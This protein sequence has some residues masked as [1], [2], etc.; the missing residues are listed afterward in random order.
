MSCGS[1][2]LRVRTFSEAF[3]PVAEGEHA[4][5]AVAALHARDERVERLRIDKKRPKI[6]SRDTL[7][8]SRASGGLAIQTT[9]LHEDSM[10]QPNALSLQHRHSAGYYTKS[11]DVS[12]T[13]R[14]PEF[15]ADGDLRGIHQS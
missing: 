1:G 9:W 2:G 14:R 5:S 15:A 10:Q 4:D 11:G 8:L 12:R 7:S 13:L 3:T 6:V